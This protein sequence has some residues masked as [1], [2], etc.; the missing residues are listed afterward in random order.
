MRERTIGNVEKQSTKG[1]T[2]GKLS[3]LKKSAK[4]RKKAGPKL[5]LR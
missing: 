4:C 1:G 2:V 3:A 5:G